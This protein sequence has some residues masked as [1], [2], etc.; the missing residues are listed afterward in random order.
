MESETK[1][2]TCGLRVVVSASEAR[3]LDF[4]FRCRAGTE[5]WWRCPNLTPEIEK[6]RA[7]PR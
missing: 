7:G 6:A 5:G 2:P 3:P 1:C 4:T